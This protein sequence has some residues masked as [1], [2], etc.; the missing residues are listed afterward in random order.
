MDH[1]HSLFPRRVFLSDDALQ[2]CYEDA[3]MWSEIGE[4]G[5]SRVFVT[6]D[7]I[8]VIKE[9][10]VDEESTEAER[11]EEQQARMYRIAIEFRIPRHQNITQTLAMSPSY[12]VELK[13]DCD[14]AQYITNSPEPLLKE[15][16]RICSNIFTGLDLLHFTGIIHM[17]LKPENIFMSNRVAT[18]GDFGNALMIMDADD[19]EGGTPGW[20]PPRASAK[21]GVLIDLYSACLVALGVMT[22]SPDLLAKCPHFTRELNGANIGAVCEVLIGIFQDACF[23]PES[24]PIA[25]AFVEELKF[26]I[27]GKECGLHLDGSVMRIRRVIDKLISQA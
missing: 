11:L 8:H 22:W 16:L 9:A 17:D 19:K 24:K 27:S 26:S 23:F 4:G 21:K 14:L 5:E 20:A 12:T 13:R 6:T 10:I 7:G 15:R 1:L 3:S 18:I 2:T 25:H